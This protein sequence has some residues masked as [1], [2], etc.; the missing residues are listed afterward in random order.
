[1]SLSLETDQLLSDKRL[2]KANRRRWRQVKE[3]T[4]TEH[5]RNANKLRFGDHSRIVRMLAECYSPEA[6]FERRS[7][8][9]VV[10][11][12]F[13]IIDDP[14]GT[15]RV[16]LHFAK[17]VRATKVR[18]IEIDQSALKSYDLAANSVL[19]IIASELSIEA[20]HRNTRVRFSGRYPTDSA[21]RRFIRSMGIIKHLKV[22]HEAA[23]A[24][25]T[26]AIRLF[27]KRN[28][29]YR[30]PD[31]PSKADF[32]SKVS[33]GFVD[34]INGCLRDHGRELK[35]DAVQKL[36]AYVSEILCNAEDHAG[37]IDWTV[38]GYFDNALATPLCEISIVNFGASIAETMKKIEVGSYT[39]KQIS[40]FILLHRA[41]LFGLGWQERDLL[42]V[43]ALQANVSSKNN[44]AEDT[45]GQGTVELIE[46]FQKVS[47]ECAAD[48]SPLPAMMAILSGSTYILFDGKYRLQEMPG[49][50]DH[51]K[52]IA[53]NAENTLNQKP[54]PLYVRS[55]GR[56]RFPG[57]IISIRFPL[58]AGSTV[59]LEE[60]KNE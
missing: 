41:T 11:K 39:H 14:V 49:R 25:E 58:S 50:S 17:A 52:V 28:Y 30:E 4:R 9:V 16:L 60:K 40:P 26:K 19:D 43:M 38:Q 37:F 59:A 20:R 32:K 31:D 45:R 44:N 56:L 10:P 3:F 48:Q 21:V 33:Q 13:S 27:D 8:R 7:P 53:F 5:N 51:G 12:I 36:C 23:S 34:H 18:R 55:L 1:M 54:D 15:I 6:K 22:A 46:F 42:T 57:T 29:N 35:A 24:E 47:R 2:R